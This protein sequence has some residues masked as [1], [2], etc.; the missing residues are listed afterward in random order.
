MLFALLAGGLTLATGVKAGAQASPS[1]QPPQPSQAQ[2]GQPEAQQNMPG[3]RHS[4]MAGEQPCFSTRDI[5]GRQ[6]RNE[7]G[8]RL[9]TVQDIILSLDR[10]A[11]RFAVIDY[12]GTLG[13]GKTRVAVPLKDLKWS[14]ENKEFT[15]AATRDQIESASPTPA[16]G[17]AFVA[18]Q[19]W[20]AKIDRFYGD[21][22]RLEVSEAEPPALTEPGEGR[23]FLRYP[24]PSGAAI[25]SEAQPSV[26]TGP[27][28]R[29]PT[30]ADADLLGRVNKVI[31]DC[32]GPGCGAIHAMVRD[33]VVILKGEVVT[34]AQKTDLETRIAAV[35]GVQ[36]V[37]DSE[38][39]PTANN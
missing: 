39:V 32:A 35:D 14:G 23:E 25:G 21:P 5:L 16:G 29:L 31:Q 20:T 1:A 6:V 34:G 24:A 33:G 19:P 15:M 8:D 28:M 10:D 36:K 26:G 27:S 17:W 22:G 13:F 37:V 30:P 9:G 3:T 2:P 12:G 4:A 38:L 18:N 11:A 7:A